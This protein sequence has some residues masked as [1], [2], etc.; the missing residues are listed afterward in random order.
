MQPIKTNNLLVLWVFRLLCCV[1]SGNTRHDSIRPKL[2]PKS[3]AANKD[4]VVPFGLGGGKKLACG[5][6]KKLK[7]KSIKRKRISWTQISIPRI[8]M[9]ERS[10]TSVDPVNSAQLNPAHQKKVSHSDWLKC[11]ADGRIC[12][13]TKQ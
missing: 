1:D 2:Q 8:Q 9:S 12:P 10:S 4:K 13:V 7:L 3:T 5:K 11:Q 6:M